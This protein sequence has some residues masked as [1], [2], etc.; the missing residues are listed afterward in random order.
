[1]KTQEKGITLV[2]LLVAVVI[3]LIGIVPMVRVLIFALETGNRARKITVATNLARDMAEEIRMQAFSEEFV[4]AVNQCDLIGTNPVYPYSDTNPQ[5]FGRE[6]GEDPAQTTSQGGR[7]KVFDD[8][9]DYDDWCRGDCSNTAD[10]LSDD[11][12]LETYDGYQYDGTQGYPP[13]LGYTRRVRIHN[14]ELSNRHIK[15]FTRDPFPGYTSEVNDKLIRR[16]RLDEDAG[17][18]NWSSLTDDTSGNHMQGLTPFK[19]IEVTVT[20]HG[21]GVQGV[22]IQDVSY[23]VMPVF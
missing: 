21:P 11:T 23:A 14:L 10:D 3:L 17:F 5:C 19:R 7:I 2:E 16:Y 22:E 1:M 8:V 15:Q 4:R 6:S 18:N 20:F 13:Y 12:Y 9:D